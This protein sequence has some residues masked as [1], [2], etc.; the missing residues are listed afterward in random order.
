MVRFGRVRVVLTAAML[1][2][3]T[4][5]AQVSGLETRTRISSEPPCTDFF[6]PI[7]FS[8]KSALVSV[9]ARKVIN[10]AGRHARDC[11]VTEV[12]VTGLA[13]FR[14]AALANLDLSRQRSL[15]VERALEAAGL[16]PAR[17]H[18]SALGEDGAVT[19]SGQ[20]APLRRRADVFIRFQH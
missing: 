5:C 7:Y 17:F 20:P 1:G 16:P 15:A 12:E 10:N 3:L 11:T 18:V 13:D 14:G 19:P 6:F 9:P 2:G 4:A 8:T